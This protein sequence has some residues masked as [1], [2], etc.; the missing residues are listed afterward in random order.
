MVLTNEY[1]LIHECVCGERGRKG[2]EAHMGRGTNEILYPLDKLDAS[3]SRGEEG[4]LEFTRRNSKA[5]RIPGD[6][7][8]RLEAKNPPRD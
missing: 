8:S 4:A 1:V 5:R 2:G 3:K 6:I 7:G